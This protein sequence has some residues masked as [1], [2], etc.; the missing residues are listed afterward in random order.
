M[1]LMWVF[2]RVYAKW[3]HIHFLT[4]ANFQYTSR[5]LSPKATQINASNPLM[6]CFLNYRILMETYFL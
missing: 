3:V 6:F 5:L 1:T 2:G 4:R